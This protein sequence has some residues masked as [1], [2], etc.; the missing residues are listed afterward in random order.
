MP[1]VTIRRS[2]SPNA[3]DIQQVVQPGMN[4]APKNTAQSQSQ[5]NEQITII[6]TPEEAGNNNEEIALNSEVSSLNP[7]PQVYNGTEEGSKL[8]IYAIN[9]KTV[10]FVLDVSQDPPKNAWINGINGIRKGSRE[11]RNKIRDKKLGTVTVE[12]MADLGCADYA[13]KQKE[14][15]SQACVLL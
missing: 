8:Q 9:T 14:F 13:I 4:Q 15:I 12:T 1:A 7:N 3:A 11:F 5:P 6:I 2:S 10:L